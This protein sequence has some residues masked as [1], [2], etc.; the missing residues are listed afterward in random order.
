MKR[1]VRQL[2][3]RTGFDIVRYRSA[4][5]KVVGPAEVKPVF[6]PDFDPE[7]IDII[8]TVQPYTMTSIERI[9]A[10]IQA[11]RYIVQ[12]NIP[13]DIVE[14]GVWRGGSMMAVA[15]TLRRLGKEQANLYLFDT[16]EGMTKP[17][18]TDVDYA[19]QPAL[20]EF[21]VTKRGD[22]SSSWCYAPLEEVRQNMAST[23]YDMSRVKFIKGK[24][25]ETLPGSAPDRI[26]LL[27][28]DTDWY[29]STR[30]ELTHLFPRLSTGGVLIVDDY[31]YWQ[32]HRK[33]IDEY[34]AEHGFNL[35]LNRIDFTGRIAI[36][37]VPS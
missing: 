4:P 13:G 12:A 9:F 34:L 2:I 5:P 18:A 3:R 36:K 33:A 31:G 22:D 27:R 23:G 21:E 16:Y 1:I 32:G 24:V 17:D 10:L 6:P 20:V 8:Q 14:C 37:C 30:H 7:A 26:S 35:L 11:V 29:E 28:L 19:G 25:E 15:H